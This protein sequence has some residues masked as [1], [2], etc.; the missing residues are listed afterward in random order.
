[1]KPLPFLSLD[2]PVTFKDHPGVQSAVLYTASTY[3]TST[4]FSATID[5]LIVAK[6]RNSP[7]R[8]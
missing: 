6:K 1:M 7:T 2:I 3:A 4:V 5:T 8:N